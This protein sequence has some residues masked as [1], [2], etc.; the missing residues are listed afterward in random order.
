[1]ASRL[2]K[3]EILKAISSTPARGIRGDR[4]RMHFRR[5]PGNGP[6]PFRLPVAESL[7][8]RL[9]D[10]LALEAARGQLVVAHARK[11]LE[12]FRH[13][14]GLADVVQ[15]VRNSPIHALQQGRRP[16][17]NV[18]EY[19]CG[20]CR[21]FLLKL[22]LELYIGWYYRDFTACCCIAAIL[23]RMATG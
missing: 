9:R 14:A 13:G 10:V 20:H 7:K 11:G 22:S 2:A 5:G 3:R 18:V 17:D 21:S 15:E 6:A 23:P 12:A 8:H 19:E 1:M 4:R 16:P